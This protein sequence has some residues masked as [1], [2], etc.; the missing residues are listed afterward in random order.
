MP[1]GFFP[2]LGRSRR[3]RA[4]PAHRPGVRRHSP[5]SPRRRLAR[6][7]PARCL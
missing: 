4:E 7:R 3:H 1:A 6:D 2:V 5:A